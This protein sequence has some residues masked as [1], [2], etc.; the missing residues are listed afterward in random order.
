MIKLGLTKEG[1]LLKH[2]LHEGQL[3]NRLLYGITR[4]EW[5]AAD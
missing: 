1:L 2:Q 4:E 3:K 5:L